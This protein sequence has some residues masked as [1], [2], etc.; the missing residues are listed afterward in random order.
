MT[1]GIRNGED[2]PIRYEVEVLRDGLPVVL[3]QALD[4]APGE[5]LTRTYDFH[6]PAGRALRIEARL[7]KSSNRSRVYRKVWMEPEA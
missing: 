4:L 7:F 6:S 2:M 5:S 3:W 1:I